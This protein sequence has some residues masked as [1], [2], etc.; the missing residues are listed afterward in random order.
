MNRL[1]LGIVATDVLSYIGD[2]FSALW[3]VLA[4]GLGIMDVPMLIGAAKTVFG[5]R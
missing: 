5:R 4:I 1:T 3:P 2:V